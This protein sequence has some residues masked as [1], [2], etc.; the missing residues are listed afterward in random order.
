MEF[1]KAMLAEM[2]TNTRETQAKMKDAMESQIG[3]LVSRMKAT[4]KTD[5][6]EMKVHYNPQV[7]E[8]RDAS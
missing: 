6:E 7:R 3:F 8:G 2:S 4:R 1:L 5:R